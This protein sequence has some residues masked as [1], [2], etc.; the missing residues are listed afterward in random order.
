[1]T[2]DGNGA[3]AENNKAVPGPLDNGPATNADSP[4]AAPTSSAPAAA[5]PETAAQQLSDETAPLNETQT[6]TRQR[7]TEKRGLISITGGLVTGLASQAAVLAA[8]LVY[9]G[10][11]RTNATYGYFGVDVSVLSFSVSDYVLRSVNAAFPILVVIGLITT[12]AMV[13]HEQLRS[14]LDKDADLVRRVVTRTGWGGVALVLAGL[15]LAL[16]LAG[17]NGSAIWGPAV[18]MTGFATTAYS[19]SLRNSRTPN[20]GAAY[21]AAM[22]GMTLVAFL[23]TLTAYASYIGAQKALQVTAGL[24]TQA[25]VTVYSTDSLLI[26]GPGITTADIQV[27]RS[28]YHFRY[29]G[30]R[31]LVS[32]GG[33]YF[34]LPSRWR[35]GDGPVI[36]LPITDPGIRVEFTVTKP[37]PAR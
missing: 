35:Q 23:W 17:P 3:E 24:A 34:L 6:Q 1:V 5:S 4:N 37:A 12:C 9:F 11:A 31:L 32:S 10:W 18:L 26:S 19:F 16:A 13:G 36:A 30:L 15:L 22:A 28:E 14:K 20:G 33:Q 7:E 8:V 21:L 27:P 25:D 2:L 29:D